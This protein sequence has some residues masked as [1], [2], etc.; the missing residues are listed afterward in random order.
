MR[1][2]T[3]G[4]RV[5][6]LDLVKHVHLKQQSVTIYLLGDKGSAG[7]DILNFTGEEA[8]AL[9]KYFARISSENVT[10]KPGAQVYTLADTEEDEDSEE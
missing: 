7:N 10:R 1:F 2:I 8:E 5:V 3:V 6:N 9:K 4:D